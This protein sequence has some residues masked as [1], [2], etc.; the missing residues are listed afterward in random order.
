MSFLDALGAVGRGAA[1]VGRG[2][3]DFSE[4]VRKV[5]VPRDT[6][7]FMRKI[8]AASAAGDV[9]EQLRIIQNASEYVMPEALQ[10][11][12]ENARS[13]RELQRTQADA[14]RL[15]QLQLATAQTDAD[16][17]SLDLATRLGGGEGFGVE[18]MSQLQRDIEAGTVKEPDIFSRLMERARESGR[19]EDALALERRGLTADVL[20]KERAT[21]LSKINLDQEELTLEELQ[22]VKKARQQINEAMLVGDSGV[23]SRIARIAGL[24]KLADSLSGADFSKDRVGAESGLRKEYTALNKEF[25]KVRDSYSRILTTINSDIGTSE[26]GVEG[27]AAG[28]LALIF[29]YMKML[30]PGSVVRESEFATASNTGSIPQIIWAR[31]N[32][33]LNGERLTAG[34]RQ[35]FIRQAQALYASQLGGHRGTVDT[36]A[37]I[38]ERSGLDVSNV[39]F[40]IEQTEFVERLQKNEMDPESEIAKGFSSVTQGQMGQFNKA[41]QRN[42]GGGGGGLP[43]DPSVGDTWTLDD[44]SVAVF[45]GNQW[46]I[47]DGDT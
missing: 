8:A 34:Q 35:G 31:Y 45:N 29:N 46:V 7:D 32:K 18:A 37:G 3:A 42:V 43:T 1:A 38:A 33:M 5:A 28:D 27:S 20:G 4:G 25:I 23:A 19:V 14:D 12:S 41:L 40:D 10:K 44:G 2:A 36:F 11:A 16:K 47:T 13:E 21:E 22:N 17:S 26:G 6:Q 24:D 39:V 30:D 9:D 15:R